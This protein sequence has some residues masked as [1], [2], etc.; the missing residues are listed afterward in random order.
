MKACIISGI[1]CLVFVYQLIHF[2]VIYFSLVM[3]LQFVEGNI[4]NFLSNFKLFPSGCIHSQFKV[5]FL[6]VH[7]NRHLIHIAKLLIR[8]AQRLYINTG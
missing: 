8:L 4:L 1:L 5:A 7:S 6:G 3:V 2:L